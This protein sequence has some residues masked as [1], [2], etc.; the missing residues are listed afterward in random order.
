MASTYLYVP[1]EEYPQVAA[2][3]ARWDDAAKCWYIDSDADPTRFSGWLPQD[4]GADEGFAL[5][6][7]EAF[8][9]HAMAPASHA[10]R[11]SRLSACISPAGAA[12]RSTRR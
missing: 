5:A 1:P 11:R 6:S 8:V 12:P 10:R 2:L 7:E 3:G 4:D 9:A